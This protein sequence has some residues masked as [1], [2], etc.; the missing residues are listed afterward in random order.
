MRKVGTRITGV[1]GSEEAYRQQGRGRLRMGD[2]IE[3]ENSGDTVE[4]R[5]RDQEGF[6]AGVEQGHHEGV[7]GGGGGGGAFDGPATGSGRSSRDLLKRRGSANAATGS[8][9]GGVTATEEALLRERFPPRGRM[10]GAQ[11]KGR[12]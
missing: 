4:D 11:T 6:G 2:L 12:R 8:G 10:V 5:D 3:L 1:V 7:L 9:S